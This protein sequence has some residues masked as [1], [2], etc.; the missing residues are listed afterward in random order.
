L[1]AFMCFLLALHVWGGSPIF[2]KIFVPQKWSIW[3]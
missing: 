3:L 2:S 1:L